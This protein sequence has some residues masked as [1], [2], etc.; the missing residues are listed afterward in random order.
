[1]TLLGQLAKHLQTLDRICVKD[2]EFDSYV[3]AQENVMSLRK[4]TL[5]YLG[6]KEHHICSVF[7]NDSGGK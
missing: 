3:V 7:P 5:T 2:A 6:V 4:C 1:M